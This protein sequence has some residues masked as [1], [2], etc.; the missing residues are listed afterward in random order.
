MMGIW[1]KSSLINY[2]NTFYSIDNFITNC[3]V[4][5]FRFQ[6]HCIVNDY[7]FNAIESI[8]K[9]LSYE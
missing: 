7:S 1:G 4:W 8:S 3:V 2:F 9:W 6:E 5:L